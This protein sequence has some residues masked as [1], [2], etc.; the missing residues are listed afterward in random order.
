MKKTI[1]FI[2]LS[3]LATISLTS[4][5]KQCTCT[6]PGSDVVTELEVNPEDDCNTFSNDQYGNC[7]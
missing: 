6:K 4:C 1:F 3:V 2:F 5:G 7:Y